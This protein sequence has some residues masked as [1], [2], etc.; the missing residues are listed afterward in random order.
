[1]S[2]TIPQIGLGTFRLQGQV[3]IDSVRNGIEVGYRHI[4]T[5]QIYGNE[6]EVGQAMADSGV[7]RDE[8]F[9]TTKI[10]IDNLARD[11]L[12]PSLKES[13]RKLRL[14][15]LDLTLIHWPSPNDAVAV[16]EY[17][18]ALAEAKAAGLTKAIGV[19][20]FTNA[21]LQRAVATIGATE[22]ATQQVEIH[23]FLQNRKVVEFARNLGIHITAYMP[24]AYGK[25][26]QEPVLARIAERHN[27][28]PAQVALAW[29]LQQ[30]FAVIPSSTRRVNLE[31]NMDVRAIA[32]TAEDMTEIATLERNERLANPDGLAP[33]WD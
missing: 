25:V 17:M 8:L 31:S 21:Q 10:W 15:Q 2:I 29:S 32:L 9:V 7:A 12:L 19:S 20:N 13:L 14:E 28:N 27:V 18:A 3:V 1:M 5:A 22:I 23:P 16:E 24:L 4:D 30:G 11:K 26:M 33:H 6:V